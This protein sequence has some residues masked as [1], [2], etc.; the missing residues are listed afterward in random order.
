MAEEPKESAEKPTLLSG[1]KKNDT[2]LKLIVGIGVIG[3]VLIFVSGWFD[4]GNTDSTSAEVSQSSVLSEQSIL[5]EYRQQLTEELGNMI[6]SIQGVGRTKIMLTLDSTIKNIYATDNDYQQK[7]TSQKTNLNQNADKQS[8]EKK[9]CIVVRQKDGSEKALTVG[10]EMPNVKGV[11]I[12]CD[13]GD[14]EEIREQIQSATAAAL[15]ISKSEIC[16]SKMNDE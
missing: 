1:L 11:L 8:N 15:H 2:L 6:A 5:L 7:E 4:K 13:G 10:Q 16:V 3:I 12:V 14:D 9:S